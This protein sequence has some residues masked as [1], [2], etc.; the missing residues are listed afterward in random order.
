MLLGVPVFVVIH[1]AI[2]SRIEKKLR[3]SGLPTDEKEYANL[4]HIDPIT[5]EL[6]KKAPE[7]DPEAKAPAAVKKQDAKSQSGEK[8]KT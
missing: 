5:L 4:A 1:A 3:R 8:A 2:N 6:V 7:E